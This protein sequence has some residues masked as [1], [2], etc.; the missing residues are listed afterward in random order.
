MDSPRHFL[1]I[2]YLKYKITK[3]E[4]ITKVKGRDDG[5]TLPSTRIKEWNDNN[6]PH[7]LSSC[8]DP[9]TIANAMYYL[10]E[11]TR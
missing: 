10:I 6:T 1:E 2:R 9:G 3:G 11:P 8:C 7:L 5:N 4:K